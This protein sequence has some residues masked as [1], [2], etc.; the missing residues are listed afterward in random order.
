M[1]QYNNG[2]MPYELL[3]RS[4]TMCVS[5]LGKFEPQNMTNTNPEPI[6]LCEVLNSTKCIS[7]YYTLYIFLNLHTYIL[8]KF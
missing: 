7:K 8:L 3:I 5:N 6:E 2:N 1:A 4:T